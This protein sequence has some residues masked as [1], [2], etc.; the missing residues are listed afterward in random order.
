MIEGQMV[1]TCYMHSGVQAPLQE[2]D[3]QLGLYTGIVQI[4]LSKWLGTRLVVQWKCSSILTN[5]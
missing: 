4:D 3:S 1:R 2:W 5:A